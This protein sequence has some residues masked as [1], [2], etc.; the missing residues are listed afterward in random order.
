LWS[1]NGFF[2]KSPWFHDWSGLSIAGWRAAFASLI[3]LPLVRRPV[4]SLKLLPV[5]LIF[6]A[7]NY[8]FLTSM[9]RGTAANAIWLQHTAPFGWF[10]LASCG[11]ENRLA[12]ATCWYSAFK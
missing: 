1:T 8:F 7:M 11:W 3:L 10:C 12:G 4:W 9:Q 5:A 6:A 2:A